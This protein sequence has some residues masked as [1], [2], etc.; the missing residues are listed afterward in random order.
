IDKETIAINGEEYTIDQLFYIAEEKTIQTIEGEK[1]G[2]SLEDLISKIGIGC[3]SCYEYTIK[4]KD[5]YQQTVEWDI[6]KTGVLSNI[7]KVYFPDT[8]KK[9]WVGDIVEI[10][11]K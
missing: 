5:G 4:A 2:V 1:T 11:V 7:K 10:E 8:P 9:F 3:P 6:M